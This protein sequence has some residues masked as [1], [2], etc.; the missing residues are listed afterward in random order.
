MGIQEI[1]VLFL[2][3]AA[4]GFMG[5][6]FYKSFNIRNGGGCDKRCGCAADKPIKK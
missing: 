6:K 2:F 5:W 4:A 1:I 3:A